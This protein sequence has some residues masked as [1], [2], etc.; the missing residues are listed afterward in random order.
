MAPA[1]ARAASATYSPAWRRMVAGVSERERVSLQVS[2]EMEAAEKRP[3][4]AMSQGRVRRSS[5]VG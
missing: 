3:R 1:P 2:Q 5:C 4:V